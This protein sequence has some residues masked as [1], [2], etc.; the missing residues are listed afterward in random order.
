[1]IIKIL[2]MILFI[3]NLFANVSVSVD[4]YNVIEGD[5]VA[6]SIKANG[7]NVKFP[8]IKNID[9]DDIQ[10]VS[11]SQNISIINGNYQ[12]TITKTYVFTPTHSLT[13]P[14][15][16]VIVDNKTFQTKPIHINVVKDTK[17][18]KDFKLELIAKKSAIVNY[19]N[20]ITLKF[21][22]KSNVNVDS[23]AL[24]F[25]KGDYEITPASNEKDYFKGVYKVAEVK[26]KFIPKKA[27]KIT[28][29]AKI[30]LGFRTQQVDPFGFVVAGMR[31]KTIIKRI[32]IDAKKVYDGLIGDYNI[33]LKVDKTKVNA[34]TPINATLTILGNNLNDIGDIKLNIPNVT[35]YDNK[36]KIKN[37]K[38]T[39]SFVILADNNFT[40]PPIE[41]SF[42]SIK[43]KKVKHI[44][45]KPIQI[46]VKNSNKTPIISNNQCK[47]QVIT[48]T[49]QIIKY[50]NN[51]ILAIIL[52]LVGIIIG[53][54]IGYLRQ[55]KPKIELPKNLYNKLLPYADNPKI[56]QILEKLYNKENLSKEDKKYIKEFLNE[57]KRGD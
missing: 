46:I 19:P 6:F 38:Y 54:A 11:S 57:N 44:Q 23:V 43:D 29:T 45:T 10:A 32:T 55:K 9:G 47:P 36:P 40:I 34:N 37:N 52:F 1:M 53:I 20:I 31:Y 8:N 14:S 12:K 41:L 18:D 56:K 39:K 50:K 17:T 2:F 4:K 24:S 49:N 28:L 26:Y 27:G 25:S 42:Y 51:Y 48:K 35:I 5:N 13:I 22:Q 21:Y 7:S 3:V 33:S 16:K 30:K 15:Y